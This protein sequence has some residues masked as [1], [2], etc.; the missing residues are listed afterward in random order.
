MYRFLQH[1]PLVWAGRIGLDTLHGLSEVTTAFDEFWSHSWQIKAYLKYI[2]I[3]HRHNSFP[4]FV[5]GTLCAVKHRERC[6][7]FGP[8]LPV[9]WATG[10][11]LLLDAIWR[12]QKKAFLDACI[13]TDDLIK[14]EG[15]VSMGASGFWSISWRTRS[16]R[17][18]A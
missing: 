15:L 6:Q 18:G 8:L 12:R 10:Y 14:A 5:V 16:S 11:R 3:L 17:I 7:G 13:Q 2:N 1:A 4:A 9:S